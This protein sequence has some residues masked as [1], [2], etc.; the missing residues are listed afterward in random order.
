MAEIYHLSVCYVYRDY[1]F[2]AEVR[3]NRLLVLKIYRCVFSMNGVR[4]IF[5]NNIDENEYQ[6]DLQGF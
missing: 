1:Y 3:G 2:R 5:K 4:S 6:N